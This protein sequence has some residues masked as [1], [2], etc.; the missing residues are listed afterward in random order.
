VDAERGVELDRQGGL[1]LKAAVGLNS[2]GYWLAKARKPEEAERRLLSALQLFKKSPNLFFEAC[3]Y[4]SLAYAYM[5]MGRHHDAERLLQKCAET[6]ERLSNRTEL[7]VSLLHLS[8][9]HQRMRQYHRAR[10]E[11]ARALRLATQAN[12]ASLAAD[13]RDLLLILESDA[14]SYSRIKNRNIQHVGDL[15]RDNP[16]QKL[17]LKEMARATNLSSSRLSHLFKTETGTSPAKYAKSTRMNEARYL[18]E[19]TLLSVKEI[20]FNVGLRDE[21]HFVRDFKKIYGAPPAQYRAR[22]R[23]ENKLTSR[24][25][26]NR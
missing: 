15:I 5:L 22:F 18:L 24:V 13:A 2:F 8:E 19:T 21:S 12:L 1:F 6:F 26:K 16:H 10:D 17:P 9:L 20:T 4:D 23:A 11:A 25:R 14:N 7:S 3:T